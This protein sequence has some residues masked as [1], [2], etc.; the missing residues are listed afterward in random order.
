[1]VCP[2][3]GLQKCP[4]FGC[5]GDTFGCCWLLLILMMF[6][7]K[8]TVIHH[9]I[10]VISINGMCYRGSSEMSQIHTQ[11]SHFLTAIGYC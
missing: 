10:I 6:H 8:S 9:I 3:G 2:I 5:S 7:Y 1:M 4:K 11:G